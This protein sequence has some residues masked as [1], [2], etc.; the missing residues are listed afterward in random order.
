M[1]RQDERVKVTVYVEIEIPN[2]Y[3][4]SHSTY[5]E[6]A[7]KIVNL[8]KDLYEKRLRATGIEEIKKEFPFAKAI[9]MGGMEFWWSREATICKFYSSHEVEEIKSVLDDSLGEAES[10]AKKYNLNLVKDA[11]YEP[12]LELKPVIKVWYQVHPPQ[13]KYTKRMESKRGR[14]MRVITSTALKIE[15][16]SKGKTKKV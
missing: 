14:A 16:K 8:L 4:P 9:S 6:A 1:S 5:A 10:I 3:S 2:Y 7:G 12:S 11:S 13:Q 15:V